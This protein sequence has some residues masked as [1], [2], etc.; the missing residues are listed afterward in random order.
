MLFY[1]AGLCVS[2]RGQYHESSGS[3]TIHQNFDVLNRYDL[4]E[5]L[6]PSFTE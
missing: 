3:V 1:S 4:R 6:L 5:D 2:Y